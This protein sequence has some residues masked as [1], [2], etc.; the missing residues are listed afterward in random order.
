MCLFHNDNIKID[1]KVYAPHKNF[2]EL[3]CFVLSSWL[4]IDSDELDVVVVVVVVWVL[5]FRIGS[6]LL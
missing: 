2:S 6:V 1:L 3:F 5:L 4:D